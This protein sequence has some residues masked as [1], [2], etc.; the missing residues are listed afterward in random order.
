MKHPLVLAI[1][2]ATGFGENT[3]HPA[4]QALFIAPFRVTPDG[5]MIV[6]NHLQRIRE[7]EVWRLVTFLFLPMTGTRDF[8]VLFNLYFAWWIGSSLEE[9][10]GTFKF[11][12]YYFIGALGT[13]VAALIA[14][15][16]G[17]LYLNLSLVLA[18]AAVF[19][20]VTILFFFVVPIQ[21]KWLGLLTAAFLFWA[22]NQFW[23][24]HTLATLFND[25]AVALFVLDVCLAIFDWPA[26][27]PRTPA[28]QPVAKPREE[29]SARPSPESGRPEALAE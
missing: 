29:P 13:I 9:H 15:P 20:D 26:V 1:A 21:V 14:G 19:P 22:T 7:G 5:S 16:Q 23:P 27:G 24:E 6:W 3:Q 8:F 4:L 17:N 28:A 18:L 12:V 2:F 25:V 10:W 11:N